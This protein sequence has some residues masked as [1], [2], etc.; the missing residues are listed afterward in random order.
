MQNRK[1]PERPVKQDCPGSWW[2]PKQQTE[3]GPSQFSPPHGETGA[4]STGL[5]EEM[6]H[7]PKGTLSPVFPC[8]Q[9]WGRP[10]PSRLEELGREFLQITAPGLP[11]VVGPR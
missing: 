9:G 8:Q 6:R 1:L 11:L 10:P 3:M 7:G 4:V 2:R 5:R